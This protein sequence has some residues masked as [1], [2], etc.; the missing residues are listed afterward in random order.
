[1]RAV[2]SAAIASTGLSGAACWTGTL[3]MEPGLIL[4]EAGVT[5]CDGGVF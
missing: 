2:A 1:M 3:V 4:I 5:L